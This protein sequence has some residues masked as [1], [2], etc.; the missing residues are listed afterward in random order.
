LTD[1]PEDRFVA[2]RELFVEDTKQPL[3]VRSAKPVDDGPGWWLSF[4]GHADR[5]S[6]EP[7]RGRYLEAEI[8][9]DDLRASGA[10]LWDEVVGLTVRDL[11]GHELGQVAEVY[12]AG[13]SEVYAVRGGPAGDFDV[14][15]RRE[16]VLEFDP[17]NGRLVVDAARLDLDPAPVERP[18]RQRRRPRWSRHGA[19]AR[20]TA[21][22]PA[23][24]TDGGG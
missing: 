6:V 5:S 13:E 15:A 23:A 21:D 9:L 4:E 8:A 18:S 1:Q 22:Q 16:F 12:R 10:A 11:D 20:P 19:G 7:L 3:V 2:G 17:P 14:P 24:D